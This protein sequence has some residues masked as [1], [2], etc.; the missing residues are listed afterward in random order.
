MIRLLYRRT[1]AARRRRRPDA[2]RTGCS[3]RSALTAQD[4]RDRRGHRWP[5]P[6]AGRLSV[7]DGCEGPGAGR[8]L[9]STAIRRTSRSTWAS[10]LTHAA[11]V[12]RERRAGRVRRRSTSRCASARAA[13]PTGSSGPAAPSPYAPPT[14]RRSDGAGRALRAGPSTCSTCTSPRCLLGVRDEDAAPCARS[15]S[16]SASLAREGGHRWPSPRALPRSARMATVPEVARAA[17]VPGPGPRRARVALRRDARG[18]SSSATRR[19][20]DAATGRDARASATCPTRSSTRFAR[21]DAEEAAAGPDGRPRPRSAGAL[22]AAAL[23]RRVRRGAPDAVPPTARVPRAHRRCSRPTRCVR[24]EADERRRGTLEKGSAHWLGPTMRDRRRSRDRVRSTA[25]TTSSC[26]RTRSR[27]RGSAAAPRPRSRTRC[28]CAR[29]RSCSRRAPPCASTTSRRAASWIRPARRAAG[30]CGLPPHGADPLPGRLRP[31]G[32]PEPRLY[33]RAGR[34]GDPLADPVRRVRGARAARRGLRRLL[35]RARTCGARSSSPARRSTAPCG[36]CRASPTS[37]ERFRQLWP[38]L[39]WS[40]SAGVR[41]LLEPHRA[42]LGDR[43]PEHDRTSIVPTDDFHTG[44]RI[45]SLSSARP[46]RGLVGDAALVP[47]R[48]SCGRREERLSRARRARRLGRRVLR[49]VLEVVGRGARACARSSTPLQREEPT[50]PAGPR[51]TRSRAYVDSVDGAGFLPLRLHFAVER[52]LRWAAL[53]ADA[54]AA[55][56]RA[57]RCRSCTTRTDCSAWRSSY[58][59]TR[60]RF[61]RETVFRDAPEPLAGPRRS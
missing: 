2:S 23:P 4:L 20:L 27:S 60:V 44:V 24:D 7:R 10:L 17:R 39:A 40:R 38:F 56:A 8:L 26:S 12:A 36:G 34:G 53:S 49:R 9:R 47:R 45:V 28:S 1:A 16:S 3:R 42:A 61:F 29:R 33:A 18:G 6:G 11:A 31:G 58:P 46:H 41:R 51:A 30:K 52:Y 22:L 57:A 37:E 35:A 13:R 43:R 48:A 25:G 59:E 54:H 32:Q 14:T 5:P 55:G 15:S 21:G 19:L 50:A